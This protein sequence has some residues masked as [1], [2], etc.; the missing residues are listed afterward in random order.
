[1]LQPAIS[2][3]V[4]VY[5]VE[6]Y[7]KRCIQSLLEQTLT[8]IEIILIDDGSSDSCP[9]LCDD[10]AKHSNNITVVHKQ[11]EGLG[12]ACNTGLEIAT[13]KYIAFLDSDDWVD[14]D[15]YKT[16]YEYAEHY[17][18]QMTFSGI[19][20]VNDAGQI[21]LM[22]QA[23]QLTVYNTHA[24]ILSFSMGM[25]ASEP[26]LSM[27]RIIPMSSKIILYDRKHIM[28]NNIRFES[29]RKFISED[30]LFNLDS[31]SKAKCIIEIPNTF[32][33]YYINISS[34][35]HNIRLDHFD[36]AL[37]MRQELLRRYNDMPT[38]FLT[39]VDRMF[40]GYSRVAIMHLCISKQLKCSH[41]RKT[42]MQICRNPIWKDIK[43]EY[44][45]KSMP[46]KHKIFLLCI[47]YNQF[48]GLNILSIIKN[49]L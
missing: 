6:K 30:L 35:S 5:N 23:N 47:I 31:M 44:P 2:V 8:N 48:I 28:N 20:Q 9:Q 49:N 34:L 1:M 14:A 33:N 43:K 12:M 17:N 11:N 27:E 37:V 4:P 3:I 46:I 19:R 41:K 38:D 32:Y 22:Y 26:S 40:I 24:D 13:G 25:I 10:F 21:S 29:E 7:L 16:L 39:R 42:I 18:A 36:R 15:M 45:I